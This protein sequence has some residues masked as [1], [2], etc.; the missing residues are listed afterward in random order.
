MRE[1]EGGGRKEDIKGKR[2]GG[3]ER[4]GERRMQREEGEWGNMVSIICCIEFKKSKVKEGETAH[5]HPQLT[6]KGV[7]FDRQLG[8]LEMEL[9][10]RDHLAKIFEVCEYNFLIFPVCSK[11]FPTVFYLCSFFLS[12]SIPF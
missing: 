11:L 2:G 7:G 9:R 6:V 12:L 10:L 4:R 5:I 8:G 3:G 1:R